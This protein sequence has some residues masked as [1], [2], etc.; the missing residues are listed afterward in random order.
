MR[1][2]MFVG[3]LLMFAGVVFAQEVSVYGLL[4]TGVKANGGGA[5]YNM[6]EIDVQKRRV[7]AIIGAI[8]FPDGRTAE[9]YAGPGYDFISK[10]K[11]YLHG[12][13][14]LDKQVGSNTRHALFIT[15]V[16]LT[17]G[18]V[19]PKTKWQLFAFP[20]LPAD[21]NGQFQFVL[22]R[23]HVWRETHCGSLGGGLGMYCAEQLTCQPK[24]FVSYAPPLWGRKVQIWYQYN[25]RTGQKQ[26]QLRFYGKLW[27]R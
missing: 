20:Y 4:R 6:A 15:P 5:T 1:V 23:A 18:V 16:L 26:I 11:F 25:S 8:G 24:P 17:G 21:A 14:L 22:E 7:W 2:L 9:V 13:L 3:L 27:G 12:E 19:L 10:D